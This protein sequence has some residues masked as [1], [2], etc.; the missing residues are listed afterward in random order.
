MTKI[1]LLNIFF[2][3]YLVMC[4]NEDIFY[5][6]RKMF[7]FYVFKKKNKFQT[8]THKN[9]ICH[10]WQILD[11]FSKTKTKKSFFRRKEKIIKGDISIF[12][13]YIL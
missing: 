5:Y 7:L 13:S 3:I 2:I 12:C 8:A 6:E 4:Y 9:K 10:I 11:I 1:L